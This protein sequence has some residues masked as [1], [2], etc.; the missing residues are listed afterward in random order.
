MSRTKT[1]T[2]AVTE[3]SQVSEFARHQAILLKSFFGLTTDLEFAQLS[4]LKLQEEAGEVAEAYLAYR[5]LQRADK[6]RH[7]DA[8]LKANLGK[9]LADVTVVIA[10]LANS[11]GLDFH[12]IVASRLND[13][14]ARRDGMVEVINERL[15]ASW[16]RAS[17]LGDQLELPI[18]RPDSA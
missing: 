8:E 3:L 7:T 15:T 2:Q 1:E 14:Y 17:S 5:K 9:E 13:L 4:L 6:L 11:V 12:E 18:P 10:L 16:D